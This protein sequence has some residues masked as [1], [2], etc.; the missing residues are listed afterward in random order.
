[1][2]NLK[3]LNQETLVNLALKGVEQLNENGNAVEGYPVTLDNIIS[4]LLYCGYFE[5]LLLNEKDKTN[6][7]EVDFLVAKINSNR[8]ETLEIVDQLPKLS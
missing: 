7:K 8:D 3:G 4:D 6:E 2:S 1:M 5:K